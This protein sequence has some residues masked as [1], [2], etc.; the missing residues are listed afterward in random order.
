VTFTLV[1]C[2]RWTGHS[3]DTRVQRRVRACSTQSPWQHHHHR[4]NI[5][6]ITW[7]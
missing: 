5:I 1:G 2:W 3:N 7:N 4:G 6:V